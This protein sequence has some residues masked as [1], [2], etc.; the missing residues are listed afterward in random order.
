LEKPEIYSDYVKVNEIQGKIESIT[1]EHENYSEE[2][3]MLSE[4][5][6]NM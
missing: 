2:W 4:E 3:L 1:K 6:E 5:L